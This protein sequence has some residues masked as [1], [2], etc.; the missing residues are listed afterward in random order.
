VIEFNGVYD[1]VLHVNIQWSD[2]WW[3]WDRTA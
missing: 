3:R 2:V 1:S